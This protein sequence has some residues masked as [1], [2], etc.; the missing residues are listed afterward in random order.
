MV[1]NWLDLFS[2]TAMDLEMQR[3]MMENSVQRL[4][5]DTSRQVEMTSEDAAWLEDLFQR[6]VTPARDEI[7]S[8]EGGMETEVI[9]PWEQQET[10]EVRE[11]P[12]LTDA[13][14]QWH[15][16]EGQNACA[17]CAQQFIIN[18]FLHTDYSEAELSQLAQER[19]WFDPRGGTSPYDVGNILSEFGIENH[20]SWPG[21]LE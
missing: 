11:L 18:E 4:L 1:D 10:G 19:G 14:D 8:A 5:E 16:Q 21:S 9:S 20:M 3:V 2:D 6:L 13:M 15:V 17:V 12:P 7:V